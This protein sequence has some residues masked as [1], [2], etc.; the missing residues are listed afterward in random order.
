MIYS[1]YPPKYEY[2]YFVANRHTQ[3]AQGHKEIRNGDNTRGNYFINLPKGEAKTTVNYIADEW[4]FFPVT[5]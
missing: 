3:S 4:G 1:Q 5:R 2:N